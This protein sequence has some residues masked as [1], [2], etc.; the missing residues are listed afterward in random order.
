V[1]ARP[2]TGH[3]LLPIKFAGLNMGSYLECRDAGA[4][5][6]PDP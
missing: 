6:S 1:R 4:L 2:N 3:L 5:T